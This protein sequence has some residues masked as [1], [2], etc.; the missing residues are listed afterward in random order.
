M[1]TSVSGINTP[2]KAVQETIQ[3]F[4]MLLMPPTSR[5]LVRIERGISMKVSTSGTFAIQFAVI[6]DT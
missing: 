5:L 3:V 1:V 2:T 6:N 4:S